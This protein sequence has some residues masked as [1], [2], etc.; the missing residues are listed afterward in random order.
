ML[1]DVIDRLEGINL[2][3]GVNIEWRFYRDV[4]TAARLDS[5]GRASTVATR[6]KDK[7][8]FE[9]GG[10]G[11]SARLDYPSGR[12]GGV[13][14][15]GSERFVE[16]PRMQRLPSATITRCRG[17]AQYMIAGSIFKFPCR[18]GNAPSTL[19]LRGK[20]PAWL[21]AYPD[22]LKNGDH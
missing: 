21:A 4:L 7:G 9:P 16:R 11:V 6:A 3:I 15:S 14:L 13:R 5:A 1:P 12:D 19:R 18:T 22:T 17:G 8:Y 20:F 10:A 2:N